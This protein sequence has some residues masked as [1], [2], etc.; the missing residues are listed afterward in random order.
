MT[1]HDAHRVEILGCQVD[2]LTMNESLEKIETMIL[3][4]RP[5]Q[6]VVVNADKI[7]KAHADPKIREIVNSCDMINADGMAVLWAAKMLGRPLKERVT[8]IDLFECLVEHAE[9][10]GWRV[11]FLGA[12]QAV[13]ESL[14]GRFHARFP[15]L[16]VAGFR[17]GYWRASE[18]TSI[19]E[20]IAQARADILF[21]A[22]SSPKKEEFLNRY[23]KSMRVPFAMGVG[24]SFDVVAG[25]TKRAPRWMQDC[26]L[27]W[28]FRFLQEPRRMFHRYFVEDMSFFRLLAIAWWTERMQGVRRSRG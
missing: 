6:H 24:G 27:E 19:V 28:F 16:V 3:S 2:N 15:R 21:V 8:G 22:I 5:H 1:N 11:Y 7:V 17:N 4:R 9:A 26:G 25:L 18:E 10:K 23:Q 13:L 20:E 14:V 12:R